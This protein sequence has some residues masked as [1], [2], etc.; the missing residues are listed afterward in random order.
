MYVPG[1]N[2][3]EDQATILALLRSRGIG[4]LVTSDATG[5][6]D[7]TVLPFLVDDEMTSMRAHL[8]RANQHWRTLHGSGALM[9]VPVTDAYV[10]PSWYPTKATDP[11]VVPTWN[12]EVVHVHGSVRVDDDPQFIERVVRDLTDRHEARRVDTNS[13]PPA[14]SVDDAPSEYIDRQLRAV[15]G[16]ELT[17]TAI[18]AKRK[19][20]Q[21]RSDAD[22]RGVADGLGRSATPGDRSVAASMD[23]DHPTA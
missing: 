16:I 11:R 18:E 7:A 21:N 19:L 8:A 5:S 17:I 10:S 9:I 2:A 23:L 1:P 22:R 15:V 20:S 4:H 13:A 6:L 3:V 14:W 12:Y